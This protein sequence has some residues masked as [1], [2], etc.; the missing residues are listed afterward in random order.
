MAPPPVSRQ[1]EDP[2]TDPIPRLGLEMPKPPARR[3]TGTAGYAAPPRRAELPRRGHRQ[4]ELDEPD[5]DDGR[6]QRSRQAPPVAPLVARTAAPLGPH[7]PAPLGPHAPA[8]FGPRTPAPKSAQPAPP[9]T[10]PPTPPP[11]SMPLAL[12]PKPAPPVSQPPTQ[13][14]AGPKAPPARR[15]DDDEDFLDDEYDEYDDELDEDDEEDEDLDDESPAKEWL[16][17]ASQ[18][19]IGAIG[20]AALWLGFQWLWQSMP[21]AALVVALV[22]ITALVWIVRRIR[23][24]DDLQTIVVTVLVGLFVTVSPAAL[25]LLDR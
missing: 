2:P 16:A 10:A 22:V 11:K 13:M 14:S 7:A 21:V 5:W 3:D 6:A 1:R 8:P 19:T 24:S 12:A 18:L 17:M 23:R 20:G 15:P 25:L 4:P 9:K